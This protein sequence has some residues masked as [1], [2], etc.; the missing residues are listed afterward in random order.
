MTRKKHKERPVGFKGVIS[1]A[2]VVAVIGMLLAFANLA[3]QDVREVN[4]PPAGDE[5]EAGQAYWV[6]GDPGTGTE[7]WR[8][9]RA[10]I[11]NFFEGEVVLAE[12]DLNQWSRAQLGALA[13]VVG[14]EEDPPRPTL[15]GLRA[16]ATA[17]DFRI[18]D[19]RLHVGTTVTVG[20]PG[21]DRRMV[22]QASGT[23]D[24]PENGLRFIH[25]SSL[26]G[27]APLGHVPVLSSVFAQEVLGLYAAL[28]EAG[29]LAPHLSRIQSAVI[30][31]DALIL[32][33][34]PRSPEEPTPEPPDE[35]TVEP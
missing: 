29:A 25:G 34:G 11:L 5:R 32:V 4:A 33:F 3:T 20:L 26:L 28:E 27:R 17:P 15:F 14:E 30:E 10:G 31:D 9:I 22:Y 8:T 13:A 12:G 6:K 35:E 23:L 18:E 1:L 24:V 21:G 2:I 19:G 16:S 7:R